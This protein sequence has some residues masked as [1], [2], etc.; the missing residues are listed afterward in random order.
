MCKAGIV[1]YLFIYLFFCGAFGVAESKQHCRPS[2]P[3]KVT[4]RIQ[5]GEVDNLRVVLY[6]ASN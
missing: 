3:A 1:V 4:E 2:Q 5:V 6:G